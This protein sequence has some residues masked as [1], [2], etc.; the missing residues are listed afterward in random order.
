MLIGKNKYGKRVHISNA[1]PDEKDYFCPLCGERLIQKHGYI[2]R[3]HFAHKKNAKLCDVW[4]YDNSNW[5]Y[6]WISK[7]PMSSQEV[8]LEKNGRKHYA[9]VLVN[10][11]VIEFYNTG[12]TDKEFQERNDFFQSFGYKV[13]WVL[14]VQEQWN[15]TIEQ[16]SSGYCYSWKYTPKMFNH[17]KALSQN[18]EIYLDYGE[19]VGKINWISPAGIKYFSIDTNDVYT[20]DS[21]VEKIQ[22]AKPTGRTLQENWDSVECSGMRCRNTVT[23]YLIQITRNPAEQKKDYNGKVYGTGVDERTMHTFD[24]PGRQIKY[25]DYPQ[26]VLEYYW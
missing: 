2:R 26:W 25:A 14:N 19:D 7:F 5:Y 4:N 15:K 10:H 8:I 23:G 22:K 12:M 13:I 1:D 3:E 17:F 18:I 24:G 11:K 9:D 6:E 20:P 16:K 21:F